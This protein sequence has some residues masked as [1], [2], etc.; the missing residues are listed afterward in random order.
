LST[1]W[2][3]QKPDHGSRG[4]PSRPVRQAVSRDSSGGARPWKGAIRGAGDS[5]PFVRR[6]TK[7]SILSVIPPPPDKKDEAGGRTLVAAAGIGSAALVA[8]LVYWR[9]AGR[10]QRHDEQR[11]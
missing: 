1:A 6:S 2:R 9:R 4:S 3:P 5:A 10:F 8:A 7:M 11:Q